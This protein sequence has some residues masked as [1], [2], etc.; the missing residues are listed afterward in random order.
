M[1][2]CEVYRLNSLC[3]IEVKGQGDSRT[4]S[5]GV[6]KSSKADG[7]SSTKDDNSRNRRTPRDWC[8]TTCISKA[9]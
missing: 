1:L 5:L 3:Y 6:F 9:C 4:C 8:V 2:L 7:E